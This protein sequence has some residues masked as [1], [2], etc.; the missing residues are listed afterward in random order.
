MKGKKKSDKSLT[1]EE[2]AL[3]TAIINLIA[4]ILEII[5]ELLS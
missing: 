2:I 3:I 5:K 1:P 4:V